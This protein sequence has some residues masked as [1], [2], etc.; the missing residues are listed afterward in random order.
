MTDARDIREEQKIIWID[1]DPGTKHRTSE[2]KK[3]GK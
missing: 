1:K 2:K 3:K